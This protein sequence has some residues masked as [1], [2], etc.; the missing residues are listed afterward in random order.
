MNYKIVLG[1]IGAAIVIG[2]VVY[3]VN[4]AMNSD[5]DKN[6]S[7]DEDSQDSQNSKKNE[8]VKSQNVRETDPDLDNVK[9]EA[10]ETISERHEEAKKVMSE[11]VN[12]IF[13]D[14]LPETTKN[15]EA[16]K[17]I[18]EDLDNL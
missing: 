10:V 18:S 9:S 14:T 6:Q 11:A 8:M 5:Q 2:G 1:I 3:F 4:K 16:K 15:E 17:K 13:D 7:N 12:V